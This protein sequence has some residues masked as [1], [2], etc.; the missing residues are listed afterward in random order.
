MALDKD[1]VVSIL[2]VKIGATVGDRYLVDSG[3]KGGE[4]IISEGQVKARPG[5]KV[6]VMPPE[7]QLRQLQ[8]KAQQQN[9]GQVQGQQ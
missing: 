1:D 7:D 4:R 8:E 9:Q 3:L 5:A 2:P 6:R